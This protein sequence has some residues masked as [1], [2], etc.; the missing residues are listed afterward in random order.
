LFI[1]FV[2][3]TNPLFGLPSCACLVDDCALEEIPFSLRRPENAPFDIQIIEFVTST[4]A[5]ESAA[6][7]TWYYL[8][9]VS[10][11]R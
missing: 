6:K 11:L 9:V 3:F 1:R 2:E 7:V 8:Q 4:K 10:V 5:D